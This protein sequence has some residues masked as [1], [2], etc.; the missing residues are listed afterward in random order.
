MISA[1]GVDAALSDLLVQVG[2]QPRPG[3]ARMAR[4]VARAIAERRH[5]LVQAG[6]GTGKSFAY[7]VPAALAGQRRVL[8]S[9][10]TLA[11]QRQLIGKDLPRVL[12]AV[13]G[14]VPAAPA[15]AVVK[16]R[17]NY[18]CRL[19]LAESEGP[20]SSDDGLFELSGRLEQ[21]AGLLRSWAE[22]TDSGDRD[23]LPHTVDAR[24][25]RA[26]SVSGREC[27]GAQRCP[28]G[29]QCFAEAARA[30]AA[31]AD[32]VVTNHTLLAIDLAGEADVLP[33]YD[34]A[35]I[36]EAHDL[37]ARMTQAST[38]S[39][40]VAMMADAARTGSGLLSAETIAGCQRAGDAYADGLRGASAS[41]ADR[42][43]ASLP[44]ALVRALA[45]VRD[46][47]HAALT[48]LSA[49][50][51]AGSLSK[52][53][54]AVAALTEVHDRAGLLL[55]QDSGLVRWVTPDPAGL[56]C[57]PLSVAD[58]LADRLL[59]DTTVVATSA[60]VKLGGSFA[61]IAHDWGLTGPGV[62]LGADGAEPGPAAGWAHLDV[63][64]PFDYRR[65]AILYVPDDLPAPGR[66]AMPDAVLSRIGALVRAA[67]GRTLVLASS[68]RAVDAIAEYLRDAA[69]ADVELLAQERGVPVGPLVAAFAEHERSVLVGTLSLWQGVDVPGPSCTCVIIDKIPFP[70][71]DEPVLAAR[72]ESAAAAGASGF[73]AVSLPHAAL[74]L[75]QGSGRLI[76]TSSDRGV[77]A[78]LDPRLHQRGY[79]RYLLESL[80]QMWRTS[81][82]PVV[83]DALRRLAAASD[84]A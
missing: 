12:A 26:M 3:Q 81:A 78:I 76:R 60:T 47:S 84:P 19:R 48:E 70:R 18:L 34:V 41:G 62:D 5:L 50:A 53:Q 68:W 28:L 43:L 17:G 7:L 14:H 83:L 82:T 35:I 56:T 44:T 36:D 8:V 39:L 30:A 55:Q 6:T 4:E 1:A 73:A 54:A 61:A 72:S 49:D 63:G 51:E 75:A 15:V 45:L 29:Q 31:D 27:V 40:S 21:Q 37:V 2:G 67:G 38:Q 23:E 71:P 22:Q 9:T 59:K 10:S 46:A 74:L 77:V 66:E 16:G 58:T 80:P 64:S 69:L 65:Q 52:R 20:S 57:A 25:W 79:G 33:E 11:L 24:V 42:R 13:G 32:I